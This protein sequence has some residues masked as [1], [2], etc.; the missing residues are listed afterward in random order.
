VTRRI[1]LSLGVAVAAGVAVA[2]Q[3][4]FRSGVDLVRVDLLVVRDGRPVT[5]LTPENFEV[6]DN[7]ARQEID[8]LSFEEVP[9]D[10][11][12]VLDN[13]RSVAGE[14]LGHLLEAGH[15][16]V[17]GLGPGDR[18]GLIG[19]SNLLHLQAEPTARLSLVHDAL[20]VVHP[21]GSTSLLDALY[22]AAVLPGRPDARRLILLFSDGLDNTSWLSASDVTEVVRESDAVIYSVGVR[23]RNRLTAPPNN[24]LLESLA[25][26]TGGRLFH[27][28]SS[29]GLRELFVRIVREMKAR[30]L[31]TYYPR[32][33]PRAGWHTL[34]IRL[35]GARGD[36]IAR[37]GYDVPG[38]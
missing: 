5:G 4:T 16:F 26:D 6:L 20:D 25:E 31:L 23:G 9:I 13:S 8:R 30:Y 33:V 18:A 38:K 37:H 27:A 28:D 34:E 10:V 11:L 22:A 15:A 3:A 14:T 35:K 17:D 12:L 2:G 19:F 7:G 1:L 36:V 32:G 29:R 24:A 21:S